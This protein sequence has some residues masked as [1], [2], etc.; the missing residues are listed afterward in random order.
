VNANLAAFN[1]ARSQSKF[2]MTFK[3]FIARKTFPLRKRLGCAPSEHKDMGGG[4]LSL[5]KVFAKSYAHTVNIE[6]FIAARDQAVGA[7]TSHG[8][9]IVTGWLDSNYLTRGDIS[10]LGGG[11]P[12]GCLAVK[13]MN[14]DKSDGPVH[15]NSIERF[16]FVIPGYVW[17]GRKSDE[18]L[19]FQISA[20]EE[21]LHTQAL[22]LNTILVQ[23]WLTDIK[24]YNNQYFS[25]LALEHLSYHPS[26]EMMR[27]VTINYFTSLAID[28]KLSIPTL[29]QTNKSIVNDD[30]VNDIYNT[31]LI[32]T[33]L[34]SLNRCL[35]GSPEDVLSHVEF[36]TKKFNMNKLNRLHFHISLVPYLCRHNSFSE[37]TAKE[38]S[39]GVDGLLKYPHNRSCLTLLL[40]FYAVE[41]NAPE[42]SRCLFALSENHTD[43][44]WLNTECIN[45]ACA[46]SITLLEQGTFQEDEYVQISYSFLA[47]LQSL[48]LDAFSRLHDHLLIDTIILYLLKIDAAPAWLQRD[49]V[50]AAIEHYGLNPYFWKSIEIS[51]DSSVWLDCD[52]AEAHRCWQAIQKG[53]NTEDMKLS[54]VSAPLTFFTDHKNQEAHHFMRVACIHE[55]AKSDSDTMAI[56]A[57]NDRLAAQTPIE[58][59]RIIA[60]PSACDF[61]FPHNEPSKQIWEHIRRE[62]G[63]ANVSYYVQKQAAHCLENITLAC[64]ADDMNSI[65]SEC[66]K[67]INFSKRISKPRHNYIGIHLCVFAIARLLPKTYDASHLLDFVI[68]GLIYAADHKHAGDVMPA[69]LQS[70][71]VMI[72][73]SHLVEHRT[74]R[75]LSAKLI[76]T[77]ETINSST[78]RQDLKSPLAAKS[79]SF[80]SD[81]IVVIY[82]CR[83]YLDTR[84]QA[85]RDTWLRDIV[86]YDIPYVISVGDGDDCL[87]DDILALNV[88]DTYENLPQKSL[89]LY[90]WIHYHTDAQYVLKID[91]DCFLNVAEYFSSLSYRKHHYYGRIIDRSHHN[92]DRI[93]HQEKSKG[94]HARYSIDKSPTPSAYADGGSSYCLSRQAVSEILKNISTAQGQHL[95]HS[96]YMEDKLMGDLLCLSQIYPAEEDLSTYIRRRTFPNAEP[97]GMWSNSFYSSSALPTKVVHLDT[98]KDMAPAYKCLD[99]HSYLPKKIWPSIRDVYLKGDAN[100]LEL[101]TCLKG[102]AELSDGDLFVISVLR[103]EI[104]MLPHFFDHYRSIG[105]KTFIMVDNLSNDGSREYILNQPD[106]ILYSADTNYNKSHYGVL[107]QQAVISNHCLNKWALIADIDEFLV[108]PDIENQN[109]ATYLQRVE[110]DGYDCVGVNMVDMYPRGD[111]AAADFKKTPP[112]ECAPY[113]DREATNSYVISGGVYSNHTSKVSGL[114]HRL[115]PDAPADAYTSQKYPLIKY[116]PWM[117]FSEGLHDA[118]GMRVLPDSIYFAHFK[119]HAGFKEKALIEIDREQ[120]YGN[121][122]EYKQYLSLLAETEGDF[123]SETCSIK[124]VN[125]RS[126]CTPLE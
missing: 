8:N 109:L 65:E 54:N 70:A 23:H 46:K 45:F 72:G 68:K 5:E 26:P 24:K 61:T 60:N 39:N 86:A 33:A 84:V 69:P 12:L 28:Y 22:E 42:I 63:D 52:V 49:L 117:M 30:G 51:M 96:S 67:L 103:N 94:S 91:D 50:A 115:N 110:E 74:L 64:N 105:V 92:M 73:Q 79:N 25:F 95:L 47:L 62:A 17:Q 111:L 48:R 13:C 102:Y 3:K 87:H 123:F 113:F 19:E 59:L 125:S 41:K 90:E 27:D 107:W 85:I 112:F 98:D 101:L 21:I 9:F 121:A 66:I 4:G 14:S 40:A 32:N 118:R 83:K 82:S 93:W 119:Y 116:K 57:V 106:V 43:S 44:N 34:K 89:K 58:R 78:V 77:C 10:L 11:E 18:T 97:V 6:L 1:D 81:T 55:L 114:R 99:S 76:D 38:I 126:F 100:Q 53:L 75:R 37:S 36:H 122:I 29:K 88:S 31:K 35:N 71:L 108:F 56:N 16:Q 15:A 104:L 7:I 120:H 2:V 124:Y 20:G 80:H